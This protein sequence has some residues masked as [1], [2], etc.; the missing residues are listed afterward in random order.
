MTNVTVL[1]LGYLRVFDL[2]GACGRDD[3]WA[4]SVEYDGRREWSHLMTDEPKEASGR[5][6]LHWSTCPL[7]A[8]EIA[9]MARSGARQLTGA[10]VLTVDRARN[11][12]WATFYVGC[13]VCNSRDE[14]RTL[15]NTM[16]IGIVL[17]LMFCVSMLKALSVR[18]NGRLLTRLSQMGADRVVDRTR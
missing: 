13:A 5:M 4:F 9:C 15:A 3:A 2:R 11:V 10:L 12:A 8:G 18:R 17:F 16:N 14:S 1:G 7:G 6:C